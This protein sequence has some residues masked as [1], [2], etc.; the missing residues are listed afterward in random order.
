MKIKR[1]PGF[2]KSSIIRNTRIGVDI[3]ND[4][5]SYQLLGAIM[6]QAL[7]D[8]STPRLR[9]HYWNDVYQFLKSIN[10]EKYL[11]AG[12]KYGVIKRIKYFGNG[13]YEDI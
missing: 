8:I 12:I 13:L 6:R 9:R 7:H 10:G 3:Q 1:N 5:C 11:Y 2:S 4:A